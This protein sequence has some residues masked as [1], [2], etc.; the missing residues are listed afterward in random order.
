MEELLRLLGL[1]DAGIAELTDDELAELRSQIAAAAADCYAE[2]ESNLTDDVL[3]A[4]ERASA[5]VATIDTTLAERATDAAD[6][7]ARARAALEA[8][9]AENDPDPE[10]EETPEEETPE[11]DAP[12]EPEAEAEAET[13]APLPVAAS[14]TPSRQ[15]RVTRVAARGLKPALQRP[16]TPG[17]LG[18]DL[19]S[20][21]LTAAANLPGHQGGK[22]IRSKKELAAMFAA[23]YSMCMTHEGGQAPTKVRVATIGKRADL[24]YDAADYLDRNAGLNI[25]KIEA[26]AGS[27]AMA[28]SGGICVNPQ[29]DYSQPV[30][31]TDARPVQDQMLVNFGADRGGVTTIPSPII[32][33]VVGAVDVWTNE[34][35]ITPSD[36]TTKP[37]L[38]VTC[39][40]EV[41]TVIEAIT[42]CL[43]FGNFKARYFPELIDAW[44]QLVNVWGA[45]FS[46]SRLLDTIG[47]GS[48]QVSVGEGL[49]AFRDVLAGLDRILAQFGSFYRTGDITFTFGLPF[50]ARNLIRADIARQLPVG[51]VD[52]TLAYA[53]TEIDRAFSVRNLNPVYFWDGETGSDQIWGAQGDGPAAGWPDSIVGYLYPAGSWL[54]LNGGELNLGLYRDDTLVGTNDVKFFFENMEAAHFRGTD[55]R[56]ITF[57]VCPDGSVAGTKSFNPCATGS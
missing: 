26:R 9:S 16:K 49:S 19:S 4:I 40:E 10:E 11:E 22:A 18:D 44:M 14:S 53:D 45:R 24:A 3:E 25:E 32:T 8:I 38:T 7:A 52:E 6:R 28:A 55:S 56:R 20:W 1:Y 35:D 46:E 36:P 42:R 15:P 47:D 23:A 48:T 54:G 57:D 41:T 33:D 12:A 27:R 17:L 13:P 2:N 39:P 43:K 5:A 31:G 30:I 29:I 37:C 50:W 21:G 34:N 51:T